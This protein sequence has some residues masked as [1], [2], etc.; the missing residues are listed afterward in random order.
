M[1]TYVGRDF[2]PAGNGMNVARDFGPAGS[3]MNVGRDFSPAESGMNVGRDFSPAWDGRTKVRRYGVRVRP[4]GICVLA[5][6][7]TLGTV[8]PLAAQSI[9]PAL[10]ASRWPAHWIRPADAP[11]HDFGV[12]HFRRSFD[13]TERA[14]TFVIH[15]SADNRYHLFVNGVRVL[16]GPARGDLDHWRFETAD[17]AANL[18]PGRNVIAAVVW[19]YGEDAPM[20]QMSHQTALIV[21]GNSEREQAVNTGAAWKARR[22][23]GRTLLPV[24]HA[25][26]FHEYYVGGPGEQ[27][28]A[29]AHEWG[30][31]APGFDDSAWASVEEIT[32]GGPRGIRDTPS[33]WMLVPRSIPPMEHTPERFARIARVEGSEPPQGFLQG[34]GPWTIPAGTTV[35]LLLDRGHL[36]SAYPEITTSGGGGSSVSLTYAEALRQPL[37]EGK[38]GPKGNRNDVEGKV[39]TGLRDRFLPDGGRRRLFTP[40]WWRTYR[41]VE[42]VIETQGEPLTVD[43]V[44]GTFTAYPF[45]QR[46]AFESDDPELSRIWEVGWR[47]AR[48]C[49]HETYMDTPYWEQ[50][51]YAGDARIQALLSLYVGGDDRLVK[52]AIELFDESRIPDGL[53]QSRYPTRLP[54]IIPP[55]SLFWIGMMHDLYRY[56]GDGEFLRPYLQGAHDVLHW[57]ESRLSPSGVLGRLEWWNFVDWVEGHGFDFGE[58]PFQDGGR[59]SILSL[60]FVLAL[61]EAAELERAFGSMARAAEYEAL[62]SRVADAVKRLAWDGSRE[63]FADTPARRTFSQHANLLAVLA[64]LVPAAGQRAFMRRVLQDTTLAQATYYFRFY[65]FRAL[66]KAGLGDD[67]LAQLTPWRDMLALGLTTWAEKPEPTRSDSHAWSAHPNYDLLTTVAG[68]EP[69]APGFRTVRIAP[70]LG[71]LRAVRAS[72]PTP[73]G[74][75]EVSYTKKGDRLSAEITLPPDVSGTFEWNGRTV[76]LRPGTQTIAP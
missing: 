74:L 73:K 52:N 29:A 2:S 7:L 60:Q 46:A 68:I 32:I 50:L 64:D 12:Y 45:E 38:K 6:L 65:L 10:L 36:T 75:V 70:H 48:L 22:D 57:F 19:N 18:R 17:I 56:S 9:N 44:Q 61:R 24:D 51:Q 66:K 26:I 15:A 25:S 67:Y 8:S 40:L 34:D 71:A 28:D 33:R 16:S 62:A 35:R 27:L 43:D 55:F 1:T 69:S 31:A 58:P 59:S 11:R 14:A 20:A 49:A 42:I 21:Q 47:T 30:W 41:Y 72:V 54:Q 13:L 39:I 37:P 23:A 3:G 4:Y 53:T 63:L 5:M 76:A